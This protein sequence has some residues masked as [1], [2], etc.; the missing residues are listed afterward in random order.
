M[1]KVHKRTTFHA[2]LHKGTTFHVF[3]HVTSNIKL[4]HNANSNMVTNL[5]NYTGAKGG[6][7]LQN[8]LLNRYI[9]CSMTL[10]YVRI[11][12]HN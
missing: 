4:I 3:F 2:F 6:H 7:R 10:N 8:V 12:T 11:L 5:L 1:C 9:I